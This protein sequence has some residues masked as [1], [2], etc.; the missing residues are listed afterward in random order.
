LSLVV[1]RELAMTSP[2][3]T[4]PLGPKERVLIWSDEMNPAPATICP[5]EMVPVVKSWIAT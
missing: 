5:V 2:T 4:Y 3:I 1:E